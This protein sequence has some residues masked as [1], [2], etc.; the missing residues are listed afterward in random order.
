MK[1]FLL[2][3]LLLSP[4][5]LYAQN[6][7]TLAGLA[8]PRMIAIDNSQLYVADEFSVFIYSLNDGTL[9]KRFGQK[10]EGPGDFRYRPSV[11]V[12]GDRLLISDSLK[13]CY[14][15]KSGEPIREQKLPGFH[16]LLIQVGKKF[17]AQRWDFDKKTKDGTVSIWLFDDQQHPQKM[18]YQS[19][20]PKPTKK[21][22]KGDPTNLVFPRLKFICGKNRIYLTPKAPGFRIEVFDSDGNPVTTIKRENYQPVKVTELHKQILIKEFTS[23]IPVLRK[24]M[25]QG[26]TYTFGFPE[27]LH[28]V[29]DIHFADSILYIK[30]FAIKDGKE[31]YLLHDRDG[32]YLRRVY[33]PPAVRDYYAF[34]NNRFYFI[35]ENEDAEEW[36]LHAVEIAPNKK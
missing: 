31:E 2:L 23:L 17:A 29:N 3:F 6:T 1:S 22:K 15:S 13:T 21:Y 11:Q 18:L 34:K 24:R 7:A 32:G 14:Y 12:L 30:T 26:V 4:L 20:P 5:G 27:Y 25:A 33:M 28:A 36:E 9:I 35:D 16:P 8:R 19:P 10:G